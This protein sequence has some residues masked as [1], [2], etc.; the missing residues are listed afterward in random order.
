VRAYENGARALERLPEDLAAVIAA[1]RL[2]KIKGIGESLKAR[3]T[4]LHE[5]G[6]CEVLE[7]LRRDLPPGYVELTRVPGLGPK[8]VQKLIAELGIDSI[9]ALRAACEAG[10]LRGVPGF[11]EKTEQKLLEGMKRLEQSQKKGR[12]LLVD[13]LDEGEALLTFVRTCPAVLRAELA[14]SLRRWQETVGDLDVVVATERPREVMDHFVRY[15]QITAVDSR[16]DTKCTVIL[17]SGM[18]VD[19]RALPLED[20]FTAL[21]HFSGSKAH[22]VKLRGLA[23]DRGLTISEWGVQFIGQPDK[24]L[25]ES[26]Q[27]LYKIL[28]MSYVPPELRED[29][30]EIE[31]AL[32]GERFDD[33]LRMDDVRGMVHC[34]TTYSDGKNTVEEMARAADALG[35]EYMTITDHSPAAHYAGGLD[36]D[37]LHRQWDEIAAVQEKVKVKLLRGT[38]SDILEDGALDYPDAVLEKLD[39]VIASIHARH[40]L[41]EDAMTK[42]VVR[43]MRHPLYKIWG[44]ALGRMLGQR[45]PFAC[46]VEEVLDAIAESRAAVEVNGDPHR[47]DMEPRWLREARKRGI[48]F[49]VSV[50]AHSTRALGYLRFAVAMARRGGVR[51]HEVLNTLPVGDFRAAVRVH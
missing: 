43:A 24:L 15:P 12:T 45:E 37:A 14:G 30:G 7:E 18:Q 20:F 6:T 8:K 47:L 1:G 25:V 38:E 39:V 33:L 29:C 21:H 35:V 50:D 2:G 11:G 19:L 3:I 36:V 13:A 46:R 22:H 9:A 48:R 42:R 41:D 34:H 16:G 49:V 44:H 28:G 51:R 23:R 31:A 27:D 32:A 26:E 5:T 4:E 17:G 40:K 10:R